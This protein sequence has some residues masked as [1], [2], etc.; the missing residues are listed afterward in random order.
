[1]EGKGWPLA[2]VVDL[3]FIAIVVLSDL[4]LILMMY[5]NRIFLALLPIFLMAEHRVG[6]MLH[7]SRKS[8]SA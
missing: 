4:G 2:D 3:A 1:M 7:P 8:S 5:L 6:A